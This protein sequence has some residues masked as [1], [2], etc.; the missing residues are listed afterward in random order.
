MVKVLFF[1]GFREQLGTRERDVEVPQPASVG[2]VLEQLVSE[3]GDNWRDVL[4]GDNVVIALNQEVCEVDAPVSD[5][6]ELA[7]YPP[8]TGG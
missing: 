1:A 4:L 5:G 6:D 2:S 3:G 7:F 8:V